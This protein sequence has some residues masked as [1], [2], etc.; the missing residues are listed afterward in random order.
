MS[1]PITT[2]VHTYLS[3]VADAACP[4]PDLSNTD[5][6]NLPYVYSTTADGP[7]AVAVMQDARR[8]GLTALWACDFVA[9]DREIPAVK[10]AEWLLMPSSSMARD[11]VR[12]YLCGVN[13]EGTEEEAFARQQDEMLGMLQLVN[14]LLSSLHIHEHVSFEPLTDNV[15]MIGQRL[16]M[17]KEASGWKFA[18]ID[19]G[20]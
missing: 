7:I 2:P 9:T 20:E 18:T 11:A 15:I 19:L 16:R 10:V 5:A 12:L 13:T 17:T 3:S 14:D 8:L 6:A 1:S 4:S